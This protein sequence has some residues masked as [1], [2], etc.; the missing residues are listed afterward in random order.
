[1]K[2]GKLLSFV[3]ALTHLVDQADLTEVEVLGQAKLLMSSL[4]AQDDWLPESMAV[5]DSEHYR[6]NLLYGDPLDRF[7]LI[8]FVWGPAQRTPIHNHTVWGVIGMLRGAETQQPYRITPKGLQPAGPDQILK[9]GEV[10]CVSP[11]IGDIHTVRN[12]FDDRVSISIHVYG[13]NIGRIERTT[14]APATGLPT[15]FVSGYSNPLLPNLW[16]RED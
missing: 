14:Y 9:P 16:S 2:N 5:P 6:Q 3:T 10:A 1:M 8:S 13:G 11:T 7:S 12:A 4:V 15:R